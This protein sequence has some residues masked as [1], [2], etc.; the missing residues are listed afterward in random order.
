[1]N[2]KTYTRKNAW[3]TW[4]FNAGLLCVMIGTAMPLIMHGSEAYKWIYCAGALM[5]LCGKLLRRTPSGLP[6][7]VKRLMRI[8]IW[9]TIMFC[10]GG[11]FM[12]YT[13]GS[14]GAMDWIAFTLAGGI[15][16]IYTSIMIPRR[17]SK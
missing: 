1:M 8:E 2:D 6:M 12:W 15:I 13:L 16:L 7:N 5:S 10:A 9:A 4:I 3:T 17:M 11:F 14:Y